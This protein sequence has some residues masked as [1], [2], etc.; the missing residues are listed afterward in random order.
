MGRRKGST[1]KPKHEPELTP[2][3]RME[4]LAQLLIDTVEE[5]LKEQEHAAKSQC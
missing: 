2:E 5:E 4:I 1:N 3:E